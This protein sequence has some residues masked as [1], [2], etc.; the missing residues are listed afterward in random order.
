[1]ARNT[2]IFDVDGS[3]KGHPKTLIHYFLARGARNTHIFDVDMQDAL[4]LRQR[5]Q[6]EVCMTIW[7]GL[8]AF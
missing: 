8:G 3:W 1:G 2:H 6:K 4:N 7:G 5:K